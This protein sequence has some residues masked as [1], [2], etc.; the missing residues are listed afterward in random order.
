MFEYGSARRPYSINGQGLVTLNRREK[1]D[2][3]YLYRALWNKQQPTL[4]LADRRYRMRSDT[5]Q[6]FTVYTSEPNPLLLVQDDTIRLHPY[7][8]CQYRSDTIS[9]HGTAQVRL[10]A[11]GLGDGAIIQIGSLLRPVGRLGLPQTTNQ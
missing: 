5:L 6:H 10:S 7:A 1:K 2:A 3:Y 11:G 9:I 8:P 4:H